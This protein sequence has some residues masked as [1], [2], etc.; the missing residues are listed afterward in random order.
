[1]DEI[2][3][4][5]FG[6]HFLEPIVHFE[7]SYKI[8]PAISKAKKPTAEALGYMQKVEKRVDEVKQ[9]T[10]QDKVVIV[11]HSMGGL[12]TR[13][14]LYLFGEDSVEKAILVGTPNHGVIGASKDLCGL[15]GSKRECEDMYQDSLFLKKLNAFT[16]TKTNMYTIAASGCPKYGEEGDGV[17]SVQSVFLP[18]ANNTLVEGVCTDALQS[19]LH[20]ALINPD[21]YPQIY[22]RIVEIL[23]S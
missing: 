14:Y 23:H 19:D 21:K 1:M 17:V 6:V 16:P 8:K 2:I 10:G 3:F 18:Y 15:I 7:V 11:A 9:K 5:A 12:V 13:Q 22:D 4:K 20:R